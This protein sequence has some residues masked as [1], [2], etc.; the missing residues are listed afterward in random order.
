M[1][2]MILTA[3]ILAACGREEP[4]FK[5]GRVAALMQP[6]TPM[7]TEANVRSY[8]ACAP[9]LVKAAPQL[10]NDMARYMEA[11]ANRTPMKALAAGGDLL[12]RLDVFAKSHGFATWFEL[13]KVHMR[14]WTCRA[15]EKM[16][17]ELPKAKA[18]MEDQR[19]KIEAQLA[20]PKTP[21][22]QKEQLR[23]TLESLKLSESTFASMS[24]LLRVPPQ[25]MEVYRRAKGEIEALEKKLK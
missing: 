18:S 15:Q 21:A 17:A 6:D 24:N 5:G 8:V 13:E 10:A 2:Y 1:R 20:D 9:D 4:R 16:E 23:K 7:L 11:E 14:V 22:N 12:G 19:K 3:C 25:D